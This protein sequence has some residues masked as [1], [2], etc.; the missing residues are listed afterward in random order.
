M[1]II[2]NLNKAQEEAVK[3]TK[4]PVLIV[5]GAG[6]GKTRVITHRI[7]YLISKN[8]KPDNILAVTFT[9]K[10]ADEMRERVF[11]LI[12]SSKIL[13]SQKSRNAP[14]ISDSAPQNNGNSVSRTGR[15]TE[16]F[17]FLPFIGTFHS[18]GVKILR[19][20][21]KYANISRN[22]SILDEDD[23]LKLIKESLKELE[24]SPDQW[25][26][27]KMRALISK[28]KNQLKDDAAFLEESQGQ[29]FLQTL[30]KIWQKY[31]EKL[32]ENQAF[33]FDDLIT[34]TVGLFQ[35]NPEILKRYQ[36]QW[37]YIHIDEYQD[38]NYAQY[39]MTHLLARLHENICVV[40]DIDQAIY[41]W[42]EAD[43]KNILNFE[44]D[45]PKAKIITLEENYRSAKNILDAANEIIIKNRFRVPKNLFTNKKENGSIFAFNAGD[46]I[47]EAN[48]VADAATKLL[49]NGEN[50]S[51]I[52]V[53]YRTNFQSRVIEE[54]FLANNIPYQVVGVKFYARKEVKDIL[55][56]IKA[57]LNLKDF[58][59]V[60][61]IINTPPRGIGKVTTLKYIRHQIS[62]D[63]AKSDFA[64]FNLPKEKL[65]QLEKFGITLAAINEN[66]KILKPSSLIRFA[67][68]K[69]G[70]KK[71]LED[72]GDDGETRLENIKE[73][74][75]LAKNY[76]NLPIQE[77]INRLL[78]DAALMSDQDTMEKQNDKAR[79]MTIHAAK[80]LEFK[81]VF[82]TG[83]EENLFPHSSLGHENPEEHKEEERR[84]FY[85]ALTR[86]KDNV[87]LSWANTRTLFGDKKLNTPS[88]FLSDIPKKL[89]NHIAYNL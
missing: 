68:E 1:D 61:R 36:D 23:S 64:N 86:A 28:Q 27:K 8:I 70:Y 4:G 35:K 14:P 26:P 25:Q 40:G 30:A 15:K 50:I 60:K 41:G 83:L 2:Q 18:L 79:L 42:R 3:T 59:S 82:I 72:S 19:E 49:E 80:G 51:S 13:G 73:L 21:A 10:A 57:A 85:V 37:E 69:T 6:A 5:A 81:N 17:A 38:T 89:I 29:Y 66:S 76:D 16:Q 53:L 43:Y 48:F 77:G 39:L 67:I 22:F 47:E 75:S 63:P 84:L 12:T 33:D 45:W 65:K 52:A 46:E 71:F 31:E 44:R 24:L 54:A 55:A 11:K 74:V 62:D 88:I 7:A 34:K 20:N 58:I 87:F 56:Y 32:K 9:N 78:S